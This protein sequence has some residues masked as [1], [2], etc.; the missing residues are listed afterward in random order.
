MNVQSEIII[1]LKIVS[2]DEVHYFCTHEQTMYCYC[3]F[4]NF[5][6]GLLLKVIVSIQTI[7]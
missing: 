7:F 2:Q 4:T 5:S 1:N 6:F 3:I